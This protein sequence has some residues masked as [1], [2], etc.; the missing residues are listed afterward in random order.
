MAP[1]KGG[2]APDLEKFLDTL[3]SRPVDASVES[4]IS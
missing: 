1:P 4:L 2:Y 3:K